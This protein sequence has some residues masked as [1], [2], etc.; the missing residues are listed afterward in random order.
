MG[1]LL[2]ETGDEYDEEVEARVGEE[3]KELE[4]EDVAEY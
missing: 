3:E 2:E 4:E 1:A